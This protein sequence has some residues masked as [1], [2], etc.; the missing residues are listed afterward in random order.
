MS[1]AID[2]GAADALLRPAGRRRRARPR[3]SRGRDRRWQPAGQERADH[4]GQH[5]AA[6][7]RRQGRRRDVG[8][9]DVA[10]GVGD[11]GV[12][13]LQHDHL[14]P[15]AAAAAAAASRAHRRRPAAWVAA[16]PGEARELAGVRG[17]HQR[18]R[19]SAR[20][21]RDSAAS[22]FRAVGVD[23]HRRAAARAMKLRARRCVAG[24]RPSPGPMTSASYDAASVASA[25]PAGRA[26]SGRAPPRRGASR[27]APGR[28]PSRRGDHRLGRGE[29]DEPGA[30]PHRRRA[31]RGGRP[32]RTRSSRPR[33][34]ARPK[35]PLWARVGARREV[36]RRPSAG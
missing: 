10:V 27:S 36:A 9:Q 13:A 6:A 3:R 2:P 8:A 34:A 16:P 35:S 24:W 29:A 5:V 15:L 4:A 7:R 31:R 18:R 19:A 33:R 32:R 21:Q 11:D 12:R 23:D 30:G 1:R 26:R 20:H 17:Q 14:A 28:A 22:A 25:A